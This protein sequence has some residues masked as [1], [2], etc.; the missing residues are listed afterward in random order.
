M[1]PRTGFSLYSSMPCMRGIIV[2]DIPFTFMMRMVGV[3]VAAD[4]V[5]VLF[6]LLTPMPS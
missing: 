1:T 3:P 6:S 4:T 2:W 5:C